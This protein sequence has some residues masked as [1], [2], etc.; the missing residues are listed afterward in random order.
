[1]V[2]YCCKFLA[3]SHL[4]VERE[5]VPRWFYLLLVAC[6][7]WRR[8]VL[9]DVVWSFPI[10]ISVHS[11]ICSSR[12]CGYCGGARSPDTSFVVNDGLR[13][14][15][16]LCQEAAEDVCPVC[17]RGVHFNGACRLWLQ[18]AD[19]RFALQPH[20]QTGMCPDCSAAFVGVASACRSRRNVGCLGRQLSEHVRGMVASV[21]SG[22]GHLTV[23]A[24]FYYEIL[25]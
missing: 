6:R 20:E 14:R 4:K 2:Y 25:I 23:R 24:Q 21:R 10:A 17:A 9:L 1:M 11:M 3:T 8:F 19:R 5:K 18:G 22:A 12:F 16:R 13:G 7:G 15:C